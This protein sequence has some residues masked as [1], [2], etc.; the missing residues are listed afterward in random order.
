MEGRRP[1][2]P[3]VFKLLYQCV[4]MEIIDLNNR[5]S[6]L[7][8]KKKTTP[9]TAR[10]VSDIPFLCRRGA[11]PTAECP[12]PSMC[13]SVSLGFSVPCFRSLPCSPSVWTVP[14][15]PCVSPSHWVSL[16]PVSDLCPA[17]PLCAA[18]R[19]HSHVSAAHQS[20]I[21]WWWQTP[22]SKTYD[23]VKWSFGFEYTLSRATSGH[24]WQNGRENGGT[25]P[26]WMRYFNINPMGVAWSIL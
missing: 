23:L 13:L 16:S 15:L 25:V 21:S 8:A 10:A 1:H 6:V 4:H 18:C 7:R 3:Y 19:R 11:V 24:R 5:L 9:V 20:F 17:V 2:C 26:P 22:P 12:G 14:V